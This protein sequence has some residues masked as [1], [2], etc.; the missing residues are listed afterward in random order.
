[1]DILLC[2][3]IFSCESTERRSWKRLK[4]HREL[5]D[6]WVLCVC[7]VSVIVTSAQ[8]VLSVVLHAHGQWRSIWDLQETGQRSLGWCTQSYSLGHTASISWQGRCRLDMGLNV[9]VHGFH[10]GS[11][12]ISQF[13][14]LIWG[15]ICWIQS[16]GL[17]YGQNVLQ[18]SQ[19]SW[20]LKALSI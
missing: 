2:V 17:T 18:L 7:T 20:Q 13:L 8:C 11:V 16:N 19:E 15:K 12:W 3:Q 10:V 6:I 1:M 4:E 14:A 9:F 5:V